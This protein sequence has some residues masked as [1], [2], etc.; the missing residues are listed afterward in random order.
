MFRMSDEDRRDA[1]RQAWAAEQAARDAEIEKQR[2]RERKARARSARNAQ[3]KIERLRRELSEAGE[4]TEYEEEFAGS[5]TE[6]LDKFGAAFANPELGRPGDALS[7]SQKRV[8]ALMKKK[9]KEAKRVAK[10]ASETPAGEETDEAFSPVSARRPF[11]PTLASEQETAPA[12][13]P[14]PADTAP[15]R[16]RGFTP[17]VV[18]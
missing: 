1:D 18:K 7:G 11:E 9:A 15:P 6:R 5:V 10:A 2:E 3:R 14:T 16:P 17:R 8:V 13:A 12:P 4:I